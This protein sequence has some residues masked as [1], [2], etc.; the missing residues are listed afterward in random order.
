M[1]LQIEIN[2]TEKKNNAIVNHAVDEI[3]LQGNNKVSAKYE[4]HEKKLICN[5][6]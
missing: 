2:L 1:I 5:C 4:A 3:I 6:L